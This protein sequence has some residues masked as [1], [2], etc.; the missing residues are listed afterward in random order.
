M[1]KERNW[2]EAQKHFHICTQTHRVPS[3]GRVT[4]RGSISRCNELLTAR[5]YTHA[6]IRKRERDDEWEM[7][8]VRTTGTRQWVTKYLQNIIE[9]SIDAC[10]KD[11]HL[12][13]SYPHIL[14]EV[15]YLQETIHD[16]VKVNVRA[17]WR[18]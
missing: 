17:L 2:T 11:R 6:M 7:M 3:A 9:K 14:K 10:S 8:S 4:T 18:H 16:K 15:T 12:K 13:G 1:I 5:D